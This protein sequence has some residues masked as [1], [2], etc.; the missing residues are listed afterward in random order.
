M[1]SIPFQ[2]VLCATEISERHTGEHIDDMF[3][4]MLMKW[5]IAT[6]RVH[7]VLRDGGANMKKALR[8]AGVHNTDCSNHQLHLVVTG[9]AGKPYSLM[10]SYLI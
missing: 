2:V 3:R 5:S 1:Y 10:L 8:L 7:L 4:Q 6:D 9:A